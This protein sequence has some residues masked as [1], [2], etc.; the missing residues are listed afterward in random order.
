MKTYEILM[1]G[2]NFLVE[3]DGK[4]AK[5][6][7]FQSISLEV[8]SAEEAEGFAI[9]HIREDSE[10]QSITRNPQDDPPRLFVEEL[11]E[12]KNPNQNGTTLSG[13]SWF[14]ETGESNQ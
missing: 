11:A 9:K 5:K 1:A 3:V 12:I 7:F 4:I 10:L 14:A 8:E 13:R 2:E 6:G